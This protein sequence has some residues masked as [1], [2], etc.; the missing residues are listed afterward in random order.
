MPA[1]VEIILAGIADRPFAGVLVELED[2]ELARDRHHHVAARLQVR[3]G[4]IVE[5]A[6]QREIADGDR[7]RAADAAWMRAPLALDRRGRLPA[8][9]KAEAVNLAD[10]R[11]A[12]DAAE[13]AGDLAGGKAVLPELLQQF[14]AFVGPGHV[15]S[16]GPCPR[17]IR[18]RS[19]NASRPRQTQN[20]DWKLAR[21][22]TSRAF[23]G[24]TYSRPESPTRVGQAYPTAL[25]VELEGVSRECHTARRERRAR[26]GIPRV[27]RL[28]SPPSRPRWRRS[29]R[30]LRRVSTDIGRVLPA[31]R[32]TSPRCWMAARPNSSPC[33]TSVAA[34]VSRSRASSSSGAAT[35][36][37]SMRRRRWWRFAA[38]ASPIGRG[39]SP[40]CARSPLDGASMRSS[41]GTASSISTRADQRAMFP[42]FGD[43]A[44]P[45]AALLFTSGP[46]AGEAIGDLYGRAALPREPRRGGISRASR[47]ERL[48]RRRPSRRGSRMR[49]TY[50]LARRKAGLNGAGLLAVPPPWRLRA[51]PAPW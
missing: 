34:P 22:T 41:P 29:T 11:V 46:A 14:D 1:K 32:P 21:R 12:G 45:G 25:S 49:R 36:P 3:V 13:L 43:H 7:A 33:S 44:A 15:F 9:G 40:T 51:L 4:Q 35:L 2:R 17:R 24:R 48:R 6:L 18:L 27:K 28:Q 5:V 19:R 42:V 30:R 16:L 26:S 50:R 37:A 47:R 20:L 39:L 8:S 31:K 38:S 23:R 10:H